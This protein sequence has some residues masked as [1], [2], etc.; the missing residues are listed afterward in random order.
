MYRN[1][2][3]VILLLII[4]LFRI[5]HAHTHKIEQDYASGKI[6]YIEKVTYLGY[7]IFAPE[8]LPQKYRS[9]TGAPIKCA[10]GIVAEIKNSMESLSPKD[11]IFFQKVV[12]S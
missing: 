7:R 3:L 9:E 1:C 12:H 4:F 6:T 8:Q 5:V 2:C 11:Q 10:T